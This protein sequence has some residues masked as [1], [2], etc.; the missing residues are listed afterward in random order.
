MVRRNDS[1]RT[2]MALVGG[3]ARNPGVFVLL[4]HFSGARD[5]PG[6]LVASEDR[7]F[8]RGVPAGFGGVG[9]GPRGTMDRRRRA[10]LLR[11]VSAIDGGEL[12]G[13]EAEQGGCPSHRPSGGFA[14]APVRGSERRR[15][16]P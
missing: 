2:L 12:P 7:A 13:G 4:G 10:G 9:S 5:G 15:V 11:R 6:R 8:S 1:R 3:G 16:K 14:A